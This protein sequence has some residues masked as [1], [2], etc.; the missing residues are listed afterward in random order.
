MS[1]LAVMDSEAPGWTPALLVKIKD[2]YFGVFL[3]APE[4]ILG[5]EKAPK[6]I[7]DS[8]WVYYEV[9][10]FL[11]RSL[12]GDEKFLRLLD[13]PVNAYVLLSESGELILS[14]KDELRNGNRRLANNLLLNLR[15]SQLPNTHDLQLQL[16][17]AKDVIRTLYRQISS[18]AYRF[19]A[20]AVEQE[21]LIRMMEQSGAPLH[22][23]DE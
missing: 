10:H 19:G 13:Q 4:S 15:K 7:K 9:Q 22:E 14:V 12:E 11:R 6:T 5:I 20:K 16:T 2:R 18:S 21:T 1:E 8:N 23:G 17:N 3:A